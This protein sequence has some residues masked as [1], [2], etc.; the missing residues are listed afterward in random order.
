MTGVLP[1]L[2]G[3]VSG[4]VEFSILA[5][6]TVV[7]IAGLAAAALARRA[8][9]SMRH[10]VLAVTFAAFAVL[11]VAAI[12]LPPLTVDVPASALVAPSNLPSLWL[13]ISRLLRFRGA[14]RP[15]R[16]SRGALCRHGRRWFAESG[17][18]VRSFC[19]LSFAVSVLRLIRIGRQ[20]F[21]GSKLGSW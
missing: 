1:N 9:A 16:R 17:S 4:S 18:P 15:S 14:R 6:A 13:R 8:R 2:A 12:A 7:L 20:G 3:L 11:P 10:L 19:R 5:K 21:H